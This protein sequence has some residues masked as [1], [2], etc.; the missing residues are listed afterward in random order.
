ADR[1]SGYARYQDATT[2]GPASIPSG[3]TSADRTGDI[4]IRGT[5]ARSRIHASAMS[6]AVG[7]APTSTA[8]QGNTAC[9]PIA[10]IG[11][12]ASAAGAASVV[13]ASAPSGS[14]APAPSMN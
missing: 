7:S 5:S 1:G 11:S 4:S 10:A 3:R 13:T 14:P 12:S 9:G 2:E 8:S 6:A